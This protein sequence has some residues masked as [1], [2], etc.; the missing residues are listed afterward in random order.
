[1]MKFIPLISLF[2]IMAFQLV[3]FVAALCTGK[4]SMPWLTYGVWYAITVVAVGIHTACDNWHARHAY[5]VYEFFAMNASGTPVSKGEYIIK[6]GLAKHL[7][8]NVFCTHH[9]LLIDNCI[10]LV[11]VPPKADRI[12]T[13]DDL[14]EVLPDACYYLAHPLD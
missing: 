13:I 1:M 11:D 8:Q 12:D 4:K 10:D 2:A 3:L 14:A 9:T 5:G 7:V 6:H